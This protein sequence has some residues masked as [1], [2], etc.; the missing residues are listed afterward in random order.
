MFPFLCDL[1]DP[2]PIHR[3]PAYSRLSSGSICLNN[4]LRRLPFEYIIGLHDWFS[5]FHSFKIGVRRMSTDFY[6]MF[7]DLQSLI[8]GMLVA[9]TIIKSLFSRVEAN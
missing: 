3:E 7:A 2:V 6:V 9:V 1:F 4:L 8:Q 5:A